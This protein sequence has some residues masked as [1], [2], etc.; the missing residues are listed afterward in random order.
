MSVAWAC[1]WETVACL[2]ASQKQ[3]VCGGFSGTCRHTGPCQP[4]EKHL[5]RSTNQKL[6][7]ESMDWIHGLRQFWVAAMPYRLTWMSLKILLKANEISIMIRETDKEKMWA[8]LSVKI[9]FI[10]S[11]IHDIRPFTRDPVKYDGYWRHYSKCFH[12]GCIL[13][14]NHYT[15]IVRRVSQGF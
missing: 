3:G 12:R 2:A 4:A 13:R 5:N 10:D 1:A 6:E 7:A 9:E 8:G 15:F 14:Y 11:F